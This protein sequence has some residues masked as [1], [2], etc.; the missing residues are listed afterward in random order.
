MLKYTVL[1]QQYWYNSTAA[2]VL[3]QQSGFLSGPASSPVQLPV[4]SGFRSGL[5]SGPVQ[6][7]FWL[8]VR[9]PVQC[10]LASGPVRNFFLA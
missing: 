6:S 3:L 1:L 5:A 2:T 4:W 10:G 9:L 8:P 7:G